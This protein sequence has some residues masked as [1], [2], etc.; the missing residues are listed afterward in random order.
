LLSAGGTGG[1]LF[2]AQ[3]LAQ[4]LKQYVEIL[5]VAGGLDT[6][7]FFDRCTYSYHDIPSATFSISHPWN[8]IRGSCKIAQ[9]V[10]AARK[11]L[12]EYQPDLMVGFG[13]F[14]TLPVLL[15]ASWMGIPFILHEQN[16]MPGKVN[17][18]F[19]AK[20]RWNALTFPSTSEYLKGKTQLVTMP[21][22]PCTTQDPWKYYG[23]EPGPATLLVYGGSQGAQALNDVMSQIAPR[24]SHYRILHFIGAQANLQKIQS[25]YDQHGITA[26]VKHFEPNMHLALSIADLALCRAGASTICELVSHTLPA[27]LI[28]YPHAHNHQLHNAYY[29]AKTLKGGRYLEQHELDEKTL[30]LALSDLDLKV[31]RAHLQEHKKQQIAESFEALILRDL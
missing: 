10:R 25:C 28:P 19:A 20:A 29:F 14:H 21:A 2:P 6:T 7:S 16:V 23:W 13:S 18:L 27:L 3:F 12:R 9:G 11:I 26:C 24:L 15:A 1:H 30:F 5:F 31:C 8:M 4:Q 17:R 22:R